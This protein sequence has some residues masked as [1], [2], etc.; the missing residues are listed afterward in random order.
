MKEILI[1][2]KFNTAKCFCVDSD[3]YD[4]DQYARAQIKMICDNEIF[5]D[6]QIRLMPDV[7]AGKVG[8]IGLSIIYSK[9]PDKIIPNLIGSDIGCGIA[10][11]KIDKKKITKGHL[12][13]LDSVIREYIP[14]GS[15]RHDI[16]KNSFMK[17]DIHRFYH[18]CNDLH[19]LDFDRALSYI[20]TLGGG[21]HFIEI[22]KD[23]EDNYYI[24][25]HTG[26][27]FIGQCVNKYFNDKGQEYLKKKGINIP[28]EMTYLE[29]DLLEEYLKCTF[30][31]NSIAYF[32][33]YIIVKRICD[34]MK[35]IFDQYADYYDIPHN[36]ID[37]DNYGNTYIRK[38]CISSF[39]HYEWD[40]KDP[41]DIVIPI[42]MKDGIIIGKAKGNRDWNFSAPHGSGRIIKR[43]EVK[44]S[45]NL[46]MFKKEMKDVYSTSISKDTLDEAPFAY[47]NIDLIKKAIEPTVEITKILKPIYN[48]K[49]GGNE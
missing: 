39:I 34:N 12:Q 36:Y 22:D 3:I 13:K 2:G 31:C 37:E 38:G 43:S 49:A 32:N 14:S 9:K 23:D 16:G 44:E 30:Y 1:E 46:P 4:I 7:H 27:R 45:Y 28:Y 26:S 15:N 10:L 18:I 21:N 20:G 35:W 33:R 48:F 29:E 17:S 41:E 24:A 5:K 42:N 40:H 8:P 25:V 47:R 11:V 19:I 6:A